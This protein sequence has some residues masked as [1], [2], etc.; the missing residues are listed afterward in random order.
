MTPELE[1]AWQQLA[2]RRAARQY[3]ETA[4]NMA[5][6]HEAE[7]LETFTT[8]VALWQSQT[9]AIPPYLRGK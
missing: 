2:A 8:A 9:Q 1:H 6:A 5:R 7:A 4:Y 3:A